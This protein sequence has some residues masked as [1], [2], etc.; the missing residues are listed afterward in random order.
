MT[1][2]TERVYL[3]RGG[4]FLNCEPTQ[5]YVNYNLK[6]MTVAEIL[7]NP[8]DVYL[9]AYPVGEEDMDTKYLFPEELKEIKTSVQKNFLNDNLSFEKANRVIDII[10]TA[11][12]MLE[13]NIVDCIEFVTQYSKQGE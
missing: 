1:N 11:I 8:N 10:E 6:N 7:I 12:E 3:K 13:N 4:S 9:F 5:K 2:L